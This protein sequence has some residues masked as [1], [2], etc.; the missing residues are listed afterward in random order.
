M[1]P[2]LK[3]SLCV[4]ASLLALN[5]APVWGQGT[6]SSGGGS[7]SPAVSSARSGY[8]GPARFN[9]DFPGGTPPQ[10]IQAIGQATGQPVNVFIQ[11]ADAR[12]RL[13]AL[14]MNQA[15]LPQMIAALVSATSPAVTSPPAGSG[16]NFLVEN[17]APAAVA[18][19]QFCRFYP[20]AACLSPGFTADDLTAA[21]QA[22]WKMSG[23]PAPPQLAYHPETQL[24]IASGDPAKLQVIGAALE[25]VKAAA[26]PARQGLA[27]KIVME[28]LKRRKK[29]LTI[30]PAASSSS[31]TRS[32]PA[33]KMP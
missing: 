32:L 17:P 33:L 30:T 5:L 1:P 27:K 19:K 7:S 28:E 16:G 25:S 12:V 24:L 14:K 8:P 4:A 26:A 18:P 6:Q 10:L 9:L 31:P 3:K 20:V 15:T 2:N 29:A 22:G 11:T 23:D 13:P 21:I